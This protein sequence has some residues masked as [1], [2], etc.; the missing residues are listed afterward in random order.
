MRQRLSKLDIANIKKAKKI[1]LRNL[2][3]DERNVP[4]I[5]IFLD[6]KLGI[7]VP[8]NSYTAARRAVKRHTDVEPT[9]YY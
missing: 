5:Q 8:Y 3:D 7:A 4:L 2:R 9:T 6:R 1:E